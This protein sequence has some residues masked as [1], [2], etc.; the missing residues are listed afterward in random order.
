MFRT[1]KNFDLK[2]FSIQNKFR[3]I[4]NSAWNQKYISFK[5]LELVNEHRFCQNFTEN[6]NIE[7]I[8]FSSRK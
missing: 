1:P 8:S 7:Q 4:K 6:E 3:P 2:K 5:E